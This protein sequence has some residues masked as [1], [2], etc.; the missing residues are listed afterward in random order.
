VDDVVAPL[1]IER[2]YAAPVRRV[3]GAWTRPDQVARWYCPNPD[4]ETR[5]RLDVRPGGTHA[6]DM[7]SFALR[8]VYA[9]VVEG[10]RLAH[11]WAFDGGHETTVE[12]TFGAT[13]AGT[14]VVV[15]HSGFEDAGE[16]E[17]I[18]HGW[19]ATLDRLRAYLGSP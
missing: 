15:T 3:W 17:G 9:R 5:A 18:E 6:V 19:R 7:G 11:S 12:I 14:L 2:T 16:R 8:G 4:L 10:E 13:D 1:V